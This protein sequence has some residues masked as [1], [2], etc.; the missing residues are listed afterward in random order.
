M[1]TEIRYPLS[2]WIS[3]AT[4]LITAIA[5][6]ALHGLL[7]IFIVADV[8]AILVLPAVSRYELRRRQE[9]AATLKGS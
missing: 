4:A 2:F 3:I 8:G 6:V 9:E 7:F 5:A 1:P